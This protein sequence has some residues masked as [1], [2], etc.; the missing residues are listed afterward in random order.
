TG[1]RRFDLGPPSLRSDPER[2][3]PSNA[4]PFRLFLPCAGGVEELLAAELKALLPDADVRPARGGAALSGDAHAV[5]AL[6]L[7]CRLPQRVL[8]E[9]A[10]GAY[11]HED[12]LYA[13]GRHVD[14]MQWITPRHTLRVDATSQR[15]PL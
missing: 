4:G 13:L 8:I 10:E 9:V 6:N 11:R 3:R 12:D 14:W 5:M 7:E 2:G 15:S 1:A